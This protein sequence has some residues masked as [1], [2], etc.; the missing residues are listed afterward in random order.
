MYKQN[1]Q[2]QDIQIY[3]Y[4]HSYAVHVSR[5]VECM[6][7]SHVVCVTYFIRLA[8]VM[9]HQILCLRHKHGLMQMLRNSQKCAIICVSA[10][11][12][13][14]CT[15]IPKSALSSLPS[16]RDVNDGCHT[17]HVHIETEAPDHTWNKTSGSS[18]VAQLVCAVE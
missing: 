16:C 14:K 3:L 18:S 11:S 6:P 2:L 7:L 8:T 5:S 10:P 1:I 9:S 12:F 13:S 4:I 17:C 15:I